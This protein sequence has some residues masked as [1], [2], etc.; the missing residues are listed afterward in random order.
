MK[1]IMLV[2]KLGEFTIRQLQN[3]TGFKDYHY[4]AKKV[5]AMVISG[6]LEGSG[7]N[8]HRKYRVII[9]SNP[10]F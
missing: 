8:S 5:Q 3:E 1:T 6:E 4:I 2:N 10:L 9:K 7:S